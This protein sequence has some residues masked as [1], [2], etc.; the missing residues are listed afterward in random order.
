MRRMANDHQMK[1]LPHTESNAALRSLAV[2]PL[3]FFPSFDLDGA[4]EIGAVFDHDA[5]RG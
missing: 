5:R 3:R 4:F 2:A 1:E